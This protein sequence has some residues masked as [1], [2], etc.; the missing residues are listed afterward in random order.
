MFQWIYPYNNLADH[1][2]EIIHTW[3]SRCQ[4]RHMCAYLHLNIIV[5][6]MHLFFYIRKKKNVEAAHVID[7]SDM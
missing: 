4:L 2:S 3:H 6:H 1:K 7:H 5:S